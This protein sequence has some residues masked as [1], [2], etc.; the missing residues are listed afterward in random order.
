[1]R[2]TTRLLIL[3]TVLLAS[4]NGVLSAEASCFK[5][6]GVL[7]TDTSGTR[8]DCAS[9]ACYWHECHYGSTEQGTPGNYVDSCDGPPSCALDLL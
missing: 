2:P 1:M 6:T 9:G 7:D 5:Q 3:A 4:V 8:A